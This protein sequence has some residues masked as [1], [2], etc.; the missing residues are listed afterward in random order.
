MKQRKKDTPKLIVKKTEFP[1]I[2]EDGVGLATKLTKGTVQFSSNSFPLDYA[3]KNAEKGKNS[4]LE[5]AEI[6]LKWQGYSEL[7]ED[8][9]FSEMYQVLFAKFGYELR[10]NDLEKMS[11]EIAQEIGE[12]SWSRVERFSL[13]LDR[14]S[15]H[16]E[17]FIKA[18]WAEVFAEPFEELW[19]ASMAQHAYY[20]LEDDFAFGYLTALLDQKRNNEA[21]FLRGEKNLADSKLGGE[22]RPRTDN[23]RTTKTLSEMARLIGEGHTIARSASIAFKNRF[24]SSEGANKKL[25]TRHSKK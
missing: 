1:L 17:V 16:R 25:W 8:H 22:L 21:L 14:E 15:G 5:S 9:G 20:V 2:G 18:A 13:T 10:E 19:L 11:D 12:A 4:K 6:Y 23:L 24:G 7:K 3:Q